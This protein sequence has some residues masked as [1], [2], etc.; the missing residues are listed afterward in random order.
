MLIK[1]NATEK[2]EFVFL[3]VLQ[4]IRIQI[5]GIKISVSWDMETR[6]SEEQP[7]SLI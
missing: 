7:E 6:A 3:T 1:E 5:H 4:K 2:S